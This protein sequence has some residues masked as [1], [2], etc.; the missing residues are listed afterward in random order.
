MLQISYETYELFFSLTSRVFNNISNVL[1]I[2]I[3]YI[4]ILI[5]SNGA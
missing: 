1:V 5:D 2:T 3:V 4:M